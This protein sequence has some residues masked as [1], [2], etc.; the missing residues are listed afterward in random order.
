MGRVFL[1]TARFV[2]ARVLV[3]VLAL[4]LAFSDLTSLLHLP[5]IPHIPK[6][7]AAT[8]DFAIFREDTGTETVPT[9]TEPAFGVTWD[10]TVQSNGNITLAGNKSDIDLAE[11][12]KYLV[13]YNVWSEQGTSTAGADRRSAHTWLSLNG[14][15]LEYG[16][17]GGYIRDFD[18]AE[19]GYTN[20]GAIVDAAAGDDL[21]VQIRRN[22]TNPTAGINVRPATN[23]V[24]V[25]K[26]ND[27]WDYL[28]LHKSASSSDIDGDT[29]F[30]D[31][32]WDT[33]DEVDTDSFGFT[34]TSGDITLRGGADRHFL[35]TVNVQLNRTSD[36]TRENYEMRLNLGGSSIKGS[37]VTAYPVGN[38][39]GN[40]ILNDTLSYQGIIKK[41]AAGDQTLNVEVRRESSSS[42]GVTVI[43]G[44]QTAIAMAALPDEGSYIML[45]DDSG[46]QAL[47]DSRTAFD[48]NTQLEVDSYAFSH[49]TS[50][51]SSRINIDRNGDYLFFSTMFASTFGA[52]DRQPPRIDWLLDGSSVLEY[53]SHGSYIRD[54]ETF[55]GGSSGGIIVDD[56]TS[57]SFLEV[58]QFD[59]SGSPPDA[60]FS[61]NRV[62]VQGVLLDDNFFG[63]DVYVRATG[64]EASETDIPAVDVE[65]GGSF[66][67]TEGTSNRN[68]T[69][70]TLTES[71]TV[72]AQTSLDNIE[73]Y[74]DL[75]TS[76]PYDCVSESFSG[77]STESQFGSTDTN[78]F[79]GPNGSSS[80]TDSV[81]ITT[82]QTFCGYVV[83]DVTASSS[84]SETVDIS[85]NDP[86]SDVIVSGGG[87]IGPVSS[88]SPI[89][90]TVL[91][92]AELTQ[93]HYHWRNDNGSEAA[94]ASLTGSEDSTAIGFANGTVRRLRIEVSAEGSTSSPPVAYRLEYAQKGA[95]CAASTGWTDV[96]TGGGGDWDVI[97]TGNL[98]DGDD[99]TDIA[100]TTGGVTNENTSFITDNNA[101]KDTSSQTSGI[102]ATSTQFVELEYAIE[103][104]PGAPQG[105]TYCFRLTDA[106]TPLRNYD[107]YPEGTVSAD[108]DV[109]ASSSQVAN[110]DV[111]SVDNYLGGT[112]VLQRSG[113]ERTVTDITITETGTVDA[114]NG[115]NNIELWY[116]LDTNAPYDCTGEAYTG[117]GETQFGSTDIDG[118]SAANGS[119]TF[120]GS[121]V[122]S[123]TQSMCLYVILDTT[124][125]T[126]NGETINVEISN[127]SSDVVV[128]GSTVGPSAA[129][130]PTGSTTIAGP[131]LTQTHYHWRNDDDTEADA[132][133]ATGGTEDTSLLQVP[134]QSIRRLR[135]QVSNGGSVTSSAVQ[136]RLEYGTKITTCGAV[137]A[138]QDIDVGDAFVMASTSEL[139][140]GNNTTDIATSTGGVTNENTT[141]LTPNGGQKEDNSQ[142]G[143]V[144]LTTSQFVELE[145]AIEATADAAYD[146]TYC[147][148]ATD[149]G[150]ELQSYEVYPEFT[151]RENRD[152]FVQ[153][154]VT[155]ITGTTTTLTAGIDYTAPSATSAAFV[156]ITNTQ[157]TGAGESN[158]DDES[159]TADGVTA[160]VEDA[161]DLTSSFT[162]SRPSDTANS[163]D[164]RAAWEIVEFIGIAGA[165]NEMIVRANDSVTFGAASVTAT[166]TA[167]D[168]IADDN[169]VVVFITGQ[170]NPDISDADYNTS[171]ATAA[172]AAGTDEPVFTRGEAGSDAVRTSYAVVEFTGANWSIQRVEHNYTT[173]T[174]TET[175]SITA[176]GSLSRTFVHA[177]KRAGMNETGLNEMGH[178]V[179][180]SSIGQVSFR[181][182]GAPNPV[183]NPN[184]HYSVAWV[185]ENTQTGAGTLQ[186]HRSNGTIPTHACGSNPGDEP[187]AL[188][189]GIG[190]TVD[191]ENASIWVTNMSEGAGTAYPR[192][193]ISTR[194]LNGTQYEL[195][196][197]DSGLV[198]TFRTEVVEWPTAELSIR[199]NYYT[200]YVDNDALLPTD[201]WPLGGDDLG[202]NTPIAATDDPLGEGERV[203][204]RMT[205]LVN[206]AT[207]PALSKSF[208][209]QY[210]RKITSC[211]AIGSWTD[212]GVPGS[213]AIWRGYDGTPADGTT[214]ATSSLVISIAD[215]AGTYEEE[216]NTA[217]NPYQAEIGED[218]EFDWLIEQNSAV[219]KSDYCF[220]MVESD[221]T[222]LDGYNNYPTLRT[223]GYTPVSENWRW[224][225]DATSTTPTNPFA[226]ENTAP[227]DI[228]NDNE[229]KLRVTVTEVEGASG[230]NVKFGLQYSQFADF[231]DGGTFLTAT[232]TCAADSIWCFVDGGGEPNATI[233]AATLSDANACAGGVGDG[234][235]M[236]NESTSTVSTHVQSAS[237]SMEFDFAL[238]HAG[239][240]VNTVYYF[241]LYDLVNDDAVLASSSYPSLV[242]EGGSLV[243]TADG[244]SSSTVTEGVTTDIDTTPTT[245]AFGMLPFDAELEAAHRLTVDTN[246]TE[247]YQVLMYTTG[248][249]VNALGDKIDGF[250]GTNAAP[251]S[252]SIGCPVGTAGCFGYHSGDDV[253]EGGSTRFSADDTYARTSTTT[254]EEV[255]FSS[256]PAEGESEDVIFKLQ[257][258]RPQA[259]G[260]Y[261]TNIV[262]VAIP[263]F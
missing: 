252:W 2:C 107:V 56:L 25:L 140:D 42:G 243:F 144:T 75:D 68:L 225:D 122:A 49:S 119:S 111:S 131:I 3:L 204:L 84:D 207:L 1:E 40:G 238:K 187:C 112:F 188:T 93:I 194:I 61:A 110:V 105:T 44:D 120:T 15:K 79:S 142:T 103:P 156:R 153:R 234:C 197:S 123:S 171:L 109:S 28:R 125:S 146:T 95:S 23:G 32:T 219:Q 255:L 108:I 236:Y 230:Q 88:Q 175:E 67:I 33:A 165:D 6:A 87:S 76:S 141:F 189:F 138:W 127:P 213:G 201:P 139:I 7:E 102:A 133:S 158:D 53:G 121:E 86:P 48:W 12:G 159:N 45:T 124:A 126:S 80:F 135:L 193:I 13:L 22:D 148:R 54:F 181:L 239:A 96:G 232:S 55:T 5:L 128:T 14:V 16:H 43:A 34:A 50:S 18:G 78:G 36:N 31:V 157:L 195:W 92:N 261:E 90:T 57:S 147:F 220:R 114:G 210:G 167:V 200:F 71:G 8:G 104:T 164:T 66:I 151:T 180:L 263:I 177:Q 62:A 60:T 20:G 58:T 216:N 163:V 37:Y 91:R 161:S 59:E 212:I 209:L 170:Y 240:V 178:Q 130:S 27:D 174:T 19:Y 241:R 81:A 51:N 162:L 21:E 179:W 10:T 246:G 235:G 46:S 206:N 250:T 145:Y 4:V 35:V 94:A 256:T 199:Q 98:T 73:I 182:Q 242:T 65:M 30:T 186:A 257:V 259:A 245:I 97:D 143:N 254:P 70:I 217:V 99:T 69:S 101:V 150:D 136:Y 77:T 132:T 215:V 89:G 247:G 251:V 253:L 227:I 185:I 249:F 113:D 172:W 154:G 129:V 231:S 52:N 116:D 169:D 160:Y 244:T 183:D 152:Y 176:V 64:T 137:A 85:I 24:S 211:S 237:S 214:L 29:S 198:Q 223:T 208:K 196:R 233:T 26:L 228:A 191:T 117:V 155:V 190:A 205:L 83:Y 168:D 17:A 218:I 11:S 41:S 118:F 224:Y 39:S 203:R 192:P 38:S 63:T 173:A 72:N 166:G 222:V 260:Q 229:I 258:R 115:L 74:Y 262:Y 9:S 82:S 100:T 184:L 202:E 226:V 134:K 248:E 149:A 47:A 221:G 106:G